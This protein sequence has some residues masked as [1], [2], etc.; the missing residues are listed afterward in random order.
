MRLLNEERAIVSEIAGTT[1]DTIEDEITIGGIGFRF[2]DTAGIRETLDTVERIGI[3]RTY[4]KMEKAE[5]V[6]FLIAAMDVLDHEG[7]FYNELKKIK[8]QISLK[9]INRPD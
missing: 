3:E 5:V 1:R 8:N 7:S 9:T 4:E 6:L 2:I